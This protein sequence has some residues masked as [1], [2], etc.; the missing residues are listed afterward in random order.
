[1]K[2][3]D[4]N[5]PFFNDV[6][7]EGTGLEST[8]YW[9]EKNDPREL[10]IEIDYKDVKKLLENTLALV[11]PPVLTAILYIL[12]YTTL[13][14]FFMIFAFILALFT[15][16]V[17]FCISPWNKKKLI[18]T[19]K[20]IKF[21]KTSG[22]IS[23]LKKHSKK[24]EPIFDASNVEGFTVRRFKLRVDKNPEGKHLYEKYQE[25]VLHLK[26]EV[27]GP[28]SSNSKEI[29]LLIVKR[30]FKEELDEFKNLLERIIF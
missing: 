6:D 25:L 21:D 9:I 18:R 27:K 11:L 2:D 29:S 23:I 3:P 12:A 4:T 15:V 22:Q 7:F 26:N 1:M 24:N 16:S 10:I 14:S 17:P 5:H 28:E 30:M 13:F 19:R 8:F 20:K